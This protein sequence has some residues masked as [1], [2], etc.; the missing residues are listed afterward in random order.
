[1]V[2]L[3]VPL[4]GQPV[5]TAWRINT[6]GETG[7]YHLQNGTIGTLLAN[8]QQVQYD[9]SY[10]YIS[11]SGIPS[12]EIGPW[13]PNPNVPRQQNYVVAIPRQ[14]VDAITPVRTPPGA[15]GLFVNGVAIYNAWDTFSWSNATHSESPQGDG[16]WNRNGGVVEAP[17]F[18]PCDG[19]P[20]QQG[21]YHHHEYPQ[22]LGKQLGASSSEHSPL[23][24]YAFDGYPI[25]GP[26]GFDANGIVRRMESSF[27]LRTMTQRHTLPNGQTLQPNQY[28]PDVSPQFP[29][30]RYLEDFEF[31]PGLGDLDEHDG[32][33]CIT[34]D[35]PTGTYAY[36]LPIDA[37]GEPEFPYTI[38]MTFKGTPYTADFGQSRITPPSTGLSQLRVLTI[39]SFSPDRASA[40]GTVVI[41]GKGFLDTT[42][43]SF[44]DAPAS[45]VVDSDT[46]IRAAIPSNAK[47]GRLRIDRADAYVYS[48]TDFLVVVSRR[49]RAAH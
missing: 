7:T 26:W 17:G 24:G 38:G 6:A 3:T 45:F 16:I 27:R 22:C 4:C 47:S 44:H 15:I 13:G 48:T 34:P 23:M 20:Q 10:A 11:A 33:F 1:M 30:G 49:R 40:A 37:A 18:D 32:H 28:G 36:F 9:N 5:L 14:P 2:A 29:L 19:H 25:Y 31:A 46:Q 35:Y 21:A 8:V 43:V 41:N 39:S 42:A 12:Y